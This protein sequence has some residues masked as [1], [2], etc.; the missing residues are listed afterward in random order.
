MVSKWCRISSIHSMFGSHTQGSKFLRGVRGAPG[1]TGCEH[2][3]DGHLGPEPEGPSGLGMGWGASP[4]V[5]ESQAV[6]VVI[7]VCSSFSSCLFC[8][9]LN[10]VSYG[11]W[12]SPM[13]VGVCR[14]CSGIASHQTIEVVA[15]GMDVLT[16]RMGKFKLPCGRSTLVSTYHG[17]LFAAG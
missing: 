13:F 3:G 10:L 4:P 12:M 5:Q 1:S 8:K 9:G 2:R 17:Y 7:F 11:Y 16:R 14:R 6:F 15:T